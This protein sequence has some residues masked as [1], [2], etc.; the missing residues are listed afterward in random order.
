MSAACHHFTI[1]CLDLKFYRRDGELSLVGEPDEWISTTTTRHR[2]RNACVFEHK[3]VA[4]G[5]V[6]K[7]LCSA[8][9]GLLNLEGRVDSKGSFIVDSS[10]LTTMP[11]DPL[12]KPFSGIFFTNMTCAPILRDSL[13]ATSKFWTSIPEPSAECSN[14]SVS[15]QT[16]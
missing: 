12:T 11:T 2:C 9:F 15:H 14:T 13:D 1:R 4:E 5:H 6:I 8:Y 16:R 3:S 7:S 10:K